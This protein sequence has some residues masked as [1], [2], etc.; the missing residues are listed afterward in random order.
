MIVGKHV[1]KQN[2]HFA[3]TDDE[4]CEDLQNA[5]DDPTISAIWCARGGYGTVRILDK[6]DYTK[7]KEKP[8]WLIGYSD[9]TALHNQLHNEGF[10]SIHALMCTSLTKDLSKIKPAIETF[11]DALFGKP[12][13]Y[14]LEGSSLNKSGTVTGQ[15]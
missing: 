15:Y 1:F 2:N 13:S 14:T 10:E 4:R 3:G 6:I 8:K 7:F 5:M 12:L 11:K 9:I